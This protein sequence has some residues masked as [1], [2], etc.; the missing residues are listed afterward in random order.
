MKIATRLWLGLLVVIALVLGG[1]VS[2][3]VKEE[4]EQ[5]LMITL[6]DRKF[7]AHALQAAVSRGGAADDPLAE[8]RAML[9]REEVA[10]SHIG[11]RLVSPT[12]SSDLPRT[13]LPRS[14][15]AGH[16]ADDVIVTLVGDEVLTYVPIL[17]AGGVIAIELSEPEAMN[18]LLVAIRF[19]SLVLETLA[20]A[21][22]DGV[23]TFVLVGWLVGRPLA[24][25]ASLARR[26]GSGDLD[27]RV[28]W[29]GGGDEVATFA[30]EMND[31]AGARDGA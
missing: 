14:A 11:S 7:F 31:M 26:I 24:R 30:R 22:L 17:S 19:R 29:D 27:A 9:D 20:L 2:L 13:S 1:G 23:V 21:A 16:A 15:F 6:R 3:R 10:R 12:G 28:D 5:L 8:V 18:S 25:L 4:Q